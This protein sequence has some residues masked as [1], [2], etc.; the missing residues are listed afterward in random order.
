MTTDSRKKALLEL[1]ER[2]IEDALQQA[3]AEGERAATRKVLDAIGA[4]LPAMAQ[5][6]A[7]QEETADAHHDDDAS[8]HEHG[9]GA[10]MVRVKRAPK[11]LTDAALRHV[12]STETALPMEEVQRRA[13]GYDSRISEKT[14]NNTLYR[15]SDYVQDSRGEWLLRED[16]GELDL[17]NAPIVRDAREALT[18]H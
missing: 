18:A 11:G 2:A 7:L 15:G 16:G 1:I 12:L 5:R 3:F 6:K 8:D 14:V 10:A 13:V 4:A 9:V 17:T